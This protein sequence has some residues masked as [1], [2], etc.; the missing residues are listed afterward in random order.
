MGDIWGVDETA[1]ASYNLTMTTKKQ[2]I[3]RLSR[4]TIK[5]HMSYA[6][7]AQKVGCSKALVHKVLKEEGLINGRGE[8]SPASIQ[9]AR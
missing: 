2:E 4:I 3:I 6:E 7:I 5:K 1:T 9:S 8:K